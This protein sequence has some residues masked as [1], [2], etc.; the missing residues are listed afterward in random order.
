MSGLFTTYQELMSPEVQAAKVA[1]AINDEI[2]AMGEAELIAKTAEIAKLKEA[3][4][5]KEAQTHHETLG[6]F[7][8]Q[9]FLGDLEKEGVDLKGLSE[10]VKSAQAEGVSPGELGKTVARAK[11]WCDALDKAAAAKPAE[12]A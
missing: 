9:G 1:Q 2:D 12:A 4:Q 10:F 6:R 5:E 3:F 8:A 7:Q 11:E